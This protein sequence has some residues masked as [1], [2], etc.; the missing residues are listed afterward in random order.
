MLYVKCGMSI[1]AS[2]ARTYASPDIPILS[3]VFTVDTLDAALAKDCQ[4]ILTLGVCGGIAPDVRGTP[5]Q[6]GQAFIYDC[7]ITPNGS[8]DADPA[9]R[10]RFF[11]ATKYYE[12]S[13]FSSGQ[14]NT[15]NTP[16]QRAALYAQYGCP[17]VD[18]ETF[19]VAEVAHK[20]GIAWGGIRV[21]SDITTSKLPPAVI[22]A[23]NPNGTV[24]LWDIFTS[25]V[26]DPAQLSDLWQTAI[27][28][29]RSFDELDTA[30]IQT[31]P[32]FQWEQS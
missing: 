26:G 5:I 9:W 13:V 4:A 24:N 29:K 14:F 2:I 28:G 31:G 8:Y 17:L 32:H 30:C 6:I 23:L 15:A 11:A 19:A 12:A 10:K 20:R 22:D 25:L 16:A 18:D 21:I 3:G 7:C 1:E 27:N